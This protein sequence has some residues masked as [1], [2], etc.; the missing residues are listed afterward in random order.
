MFTSWSS[1][2]SGSW[3]PSW[4]D[5]ALVR[6][7]STSSSPRLCYNG[8]SLSEGSYTVS[9]TEGPSS[10]YILESKS[11]V[12]VCPCVYAMMHFMSNRTNRIPKIIYS[13]DH[14]LLHRFWLDVATRSVFS[15]ASL[16]LFW[17]DVATRFFRPRL[18]NRFWLNV[19]RFATFK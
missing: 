18:L 2:V 14:A 12:S 10:Q 4:R 17:L 13:S 6:C 7:P 3:W 1:S 9:Y 8:L 16:H 5:T 19:T 15:L 11:H